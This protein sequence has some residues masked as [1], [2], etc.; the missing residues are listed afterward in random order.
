MRTIIF[1]LIISLFS[2][3]AWGL[4]ETWTIQ[5]GAEFEWSGSWEV[6]PKKPY[7]ICNT[8]KESTSEYVEGNCVYFENGRFIAISREKSDNNPCNYF[9]EIHYDTIEGN[10]FC[11]SG[12]PYP[13]KVEINRNK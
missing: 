13:W 2:P 10:Y 12:G 7:F 3:T 6:T 5:E 11:S 4:A 8:T 1:A 9:G